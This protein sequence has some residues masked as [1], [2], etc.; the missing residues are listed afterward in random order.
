MLYKDY[1]EM[2][3]SDEGNKRFN[4]ILN[5]ALEKV[6]GVWPESL[7]DEEAYALMDSLNGFEYWPVDIDYWD[8]V[9]EIDDMRKVDVSIEY[10]GRKLC[11]LID[12]SAQK[13]E[14][15]RWLEVYFGYKHYRFYPP[16]IK[17]NAVERKLLDWGESHTN[18]PEDF[19]NSLS[20]DEVQ[21]LLRSAYGFDNCDLPTTEDGSGLS[22]YEI[23]GQYIKSMLCCLIDQGENPADIMRWY[24]LN[25][26]FNHA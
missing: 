4:E 6:E 19:A 11:E 7:T 8:L 14:L 5:S 9:E 18:S 21:T 20:S 2:L 10:T 15:D 23:V 16:E 22:R 24:N 13:E 17:A 12:T 25:L 1:E 26:A 3:K